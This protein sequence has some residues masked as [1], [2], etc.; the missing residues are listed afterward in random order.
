MVQFGK[1][2]GKID[3]PTKVNKLSARMKELLGKAMNG[4]QNAPR[5]AEM[6]IREARA[7]RVNTELEKAKKIAN[8]LFRCY[9]R[10]VDLTE[11][12]RRLKALLAEDSI[13]DSQLVSQAWNLIKELD[14]VCWPV[15]VDEMAFVRKNFL[16]NIGLNPEVDFSKELRLFMEAEKLFEERPRQAC[17]MAFKAYRLANVRAFRSLVERARAESQKLKVN[18]GLGRE[19]ARQIDEAEKLWQERRFGPA[20]SLIRRA[21][22]RPKILPD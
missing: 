14:R 22:N 17:R 7:L 2:V 15:M 10:Y 3:D 8:G 12:E 11:F 19:I 5:L 20:F 21:V 16:G 6:I 1:I 13:V 4:D 9:A 18:S